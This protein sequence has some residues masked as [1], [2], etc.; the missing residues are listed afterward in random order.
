MFI[1][2]KKKRKDKS[3]WRE[4]VE[5]YE[6]PEQHFSESLSPPLC[7]PPTP[8]FYFPFP[9]L[10]FTLSFPSASLWSHVSASLYMWPE[11]DRLSS[12]SFSNGPNPLCRKSKLQYQSF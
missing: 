8:S 1:S 3:Y 10:L 2:L 9:S 12:F 11:P 7:S 6:E 4:E 5:F